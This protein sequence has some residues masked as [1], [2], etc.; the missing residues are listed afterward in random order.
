MGE[1]DD[2]RNNLRQLIELERESGVEWLPLPPKPAPSSPAPA[3]LAANPAPTAA[4]RVAALPVATEAITSEAWTAPGDLITQP[5]DQALACIN[6]AI[7][8]CT[9]CRLCST[10]STTVPGEGK[11]TPELVFVGEGPGRDEDEQGRPFVGA[12]GQLLDRMIQAM[13]FQRSDVY[14]CNAVKCRPPGNRN[15]EPDELAACHPFLMA[16]LAV[17]RPRVICTLGNIPLRSLFGA[18]T[19]GITRMRGQRLEWQGIPVYPT[20]HPSYLLRNE[21]AK[22]P[23]WDDLKAVLAELGREPPARR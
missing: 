15:P 1:A 7:A 22:K 14:I 21:S 11:A 2:I 3:A 16:Q 20:F 9:R 10:R 6:A 12:A 18:D 4:P 13:G 17:L 5:A 8:A 19:P 23:A